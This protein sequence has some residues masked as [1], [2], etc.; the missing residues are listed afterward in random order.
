MIDKIADEYIVRYYTVYVFIFNW[1]TVMCSQESLGR[2]D[3]R[4]IEETRN[5]REKEII[6]FFF[7]QRDHY[8]LSFFYWNP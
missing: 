7:W 6:A 2:R 3:K 4:G 1:D 5:S 8:F